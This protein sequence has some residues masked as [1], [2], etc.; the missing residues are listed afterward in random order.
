AVVPLALMGALV[1]AQAAG[2]GPAIL[3][4]ILIRPALGGFAALFALSL[5][6]NAASQSRAERLH[7]VPLAL[8]LA[9]STGAL[10]LGG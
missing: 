6:G 7:G 9:A 1:V 8:I 10:A 3:P 5:F 2:I 4:G